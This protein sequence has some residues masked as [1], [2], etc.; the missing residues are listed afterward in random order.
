M[1][2]VAEACVCTHRKRTAWTSRTLAMVHKK[3]STLFFLCVAAAAAATHVWWLRVECDGQSGILGP[4][5]WINI[6]HN[7]EREQQ[8]KRRKRYRGIYYIHLCAH[9]FTNVTWSKYIHRNTYIDRDSLEAHCRFDVCYI[10]S[11]WLANWFFVISA[12]CFF[13][14]FPIV[15]CGHG[16]HFCFYS[17]GNGLDHFVRHALTM[18]YFD[19]HSLWFLFFFSFF[20]CPIWNCRPYVGH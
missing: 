19:I 2:I 18:N 5:S 11:F 14:F 1:V 10:F 3:R 7:R 20:G 4:S 6:S 15:A 17:R 13:V 12:D 8:H 16:F 9:V